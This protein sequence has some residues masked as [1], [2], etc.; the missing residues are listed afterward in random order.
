MWAR[1]YTVSLVLITIVISVV[2]LL[3]VEKVR[4]SARTS[5]T[6][7]ISGVDL[8][9]GARS[10]TI[11]LLLYSI[12]R[13]GNPTNNITWESYEDFT[14]RKGVKWTIPLS[15]GDSHRGYRVLGTNQDYF[16][17]YRVGQN[18]AL[19]FAEGTPF[20][21]L[22][23]VV[24]GA[25]VAERLQYKVGD[26]IIVSH[27]LG[28]TSFSDHDEHPFTVVGVLKRT[29]SPVDRT[30]HVSL[31][32][33]EAIHVGWE[34]GV[35]IRGQ[36][37]DISRLRNNTLQPKAITAFMVGLESRIGI[38]KFQRAVNDYKEEPL[39]AVLPGVALQELWGFMSVAEEALWIISLFVVFAG[40]TGMIAVSLAGL[41]ERR[42]EIAVL[43]AVGAGSGYISILL[44]VESAILTAT[45]T[46]FGIVVLYM[47]VWAFQGIIESN[48]GIIIALSW[49]PL[50]ELKLIS[51]LLIAGIVAGV[52]PALIAYR[53][54]LIDG[55][56]ARA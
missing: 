11:P 42:R 4:N 35:K 18:R 5:F 23:D 47:G 26:K 28:N 20:H 21:E 49:P 30:V 55:L 50:T 19:R 24:V 53:N 51:G 7:T 15:L 22:L 34:G 9:V 36:T 31:E 46:V 43:R 10:G 29:G 12:F 52:I 40:F 27:G 41:N 38:F 32:A 14:N 3:G 8:I 16:T 33:I 2:L 45:G 17:Y 25:E 54:T 56:S 44:I 37:R 39:L 13:I 1:R 6:N 48:F